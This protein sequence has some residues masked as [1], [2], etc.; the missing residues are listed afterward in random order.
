MR[1]R[2]ML[3]TAAATAMVLGTALTSYASVVASP[4]RPCAQPNGRVDA[5]AFSGGTLYIGGS[6][7]SVKNK[8]GA[9][10]ARGGLAAIDTASCDLTAWTATDRRHRARPGRVRD[11]RCTPA[12]RSS[13]S[14]G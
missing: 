11:A 12:A 2:T 7:T 1:T 13:T 4:T 10:S 14:A 5:M 9:S 6:F 3:A 8:A